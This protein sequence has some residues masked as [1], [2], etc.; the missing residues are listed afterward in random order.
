MFIIWIF[1]MVNLLV[2]IEI[3]Y[4]LFL[5]KNLSSGYCAG[6]CLKWLGDILNKNKPGYPK[7]AFFVDI[8]D[9]VQLIGLMERAKKKHDSYDINRHI[10]DHRLGCPETH[11]E[12]ISKYNEYKQ[13]KLEKKNGLPGLYYKYSEIINNDVTG[14]NRYPT[15]SPVK[16]GVMLTFRFNNN[17]QLGFHSVAAVRASEEKCY[18]FDPNYGLYEILD[19]NPELEM[20]ISLSQRYQ[21]FRML[22]QV[23]V[24]QSRMWSL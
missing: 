13:R 15:A 1:C 19:K 16:E 11:A 12:F 3:E 10:Y 22:S 17:G 24:S 9:K 2:D 8:S 6:F 14:L 4:L 20:I 7:G 23:V 5:N 18:F 21:N